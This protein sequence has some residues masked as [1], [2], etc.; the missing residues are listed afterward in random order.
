M[1]LETKTFFF[2][3]SDAKVIFD[4]QNDSVHDPELY[5][6]NL[7]E[8]MIND[9]SSSD[10]NDINNSSKNASMEGLNYYYKICCSSRGITREST[11]GLGC[12][13]ACVVLDPKTE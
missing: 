13:T 11:D 2:Y 7:G 9:S 10:L 5:S 3:S 8:K 6:S 1:K 12:D 4:D